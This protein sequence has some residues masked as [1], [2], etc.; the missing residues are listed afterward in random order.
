M[1]YCKWIGS[2]KKVAISGY[3]SVAKRL[4]NKLLENIIRT[5]YEEFIWKK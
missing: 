3:S 1:F 5:I 2:K 4:K